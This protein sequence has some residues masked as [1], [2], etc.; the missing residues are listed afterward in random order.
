MITDE[1]DAETTVSATPDKTPS[2][3]SSSRK[4]KIKMDVSDMMA[5]FGYAEETAWRIHS[6]GAASSSAREGDA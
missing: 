6:K 4:R 5:A 3:Q 2:E 1:T